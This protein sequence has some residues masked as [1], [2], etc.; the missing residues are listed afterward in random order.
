MDADAIFLATD[1]MQSRLVF[2]SLVHQYL[3]PGF[4]IGAKVQLEPSTHAVEDVYAVARPVMPY[5]GG[6][7]L[8]CHRLISP[9]RLQEEA[10]TAQERAAQRYTGLF[11]DGVNLSY[12]QYEARARGL[13]NV[14]TTL[15][16]PLER[17]VC[18]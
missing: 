2:N 8:Y 16:P 3:I 6:G 7:C 11:G 9:A 14:R 12:L 5:E 10:L 17:L 18:G 4:Q 15:L 13:W 1:T